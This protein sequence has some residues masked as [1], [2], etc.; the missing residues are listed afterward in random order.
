MALKPLRDSLAVSIVEI[1]FRDS[2]DFGT[3]GKMF[4]DTA[5]V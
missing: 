1:W 3:W 5:S 4:P 2:A